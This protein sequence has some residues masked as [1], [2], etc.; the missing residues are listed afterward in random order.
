MA[1]MST[2]V[3]TVLERCIVSV[4]PAIS[5]YDRTSHRVSVWCSAESTG[6]DRP[7]ARFAGPVELRR[8]ASDARCVATCTPINLRSSSSTAITLARFRQAWRS[9]S[10]PHCVLCRF[11]SNTQ[12]ETPE[13]LCRPPF[14]LPTGGARCGFGIRR[15]TRAGD[16]SS[17]SSTAPGALRARGNAASLPEG[18]SEVTSRSRTSPGE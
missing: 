6:P 10:R 2:A 14:R 4:L 3:I 18:S 8:R 12:P 9:S 11:D 13:R 7:A 16:L 15:V 17:A 1:K 5:A